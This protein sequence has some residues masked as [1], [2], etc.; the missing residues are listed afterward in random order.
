MKNL[1]TG[2]W[3]GVSYGVRG[4]DRAFKRGDLSSRLIVAAG[5]PPAV[6]SAVLPA[7]A[8]A[9]AEAS[10][11]EGGILPPGPKPTCF[12]A[13]FAFIAVKSPCFRSRILRISRLKLP[14]FYFSFS[15]FPQTPHLVGFRFSAFPLSAFLAATFCLLLVPSPAPANPTG[16]AVAQGAASFN[17]TGLATDHQHFRQHPHQLVEL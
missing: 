15:A 5:V 1:W 17:T 8:L 9:A 7:K 4:H 3:C 13:L 6:L 2:V 11:E 10:A 14:C 16:G 12:S